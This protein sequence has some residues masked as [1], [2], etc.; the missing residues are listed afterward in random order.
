MSE[1]EQK[2]L[3]LLCAIFWA[4]TSAP[5]VARR[6]QHVRLVTGIEVDLGDMSKSTAEVLAKGY[7]K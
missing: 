2:V 4:V 6:A 1:F 5:G 3:R 7:E